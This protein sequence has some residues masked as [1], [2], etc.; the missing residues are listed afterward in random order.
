M[1]H[2]LSERAL[3]GL[4]QALAANAEG[5]DR[6][7]QFPQR[8]FDLL[9]RHGLLALTVPRALG[10]GGADLASAR[11]VIAAVGKGCPSTALILAMQYL[12]HSRLQE[13]ARWPEHLRHRVARDAVAHGALINALRVE[14]ELG[15][16]A[17]GGLPATLARRNAD[18]WRLSGRKLYSTG[19]H[20]LSW[21]LVWARSDD[22]DPLVGGFLVHKD[23]PGIT[24]VDD[25][26]H[27]GMRATCS[28][29]VRFDDVRIPLDHA[30]SVSPASA[31][32]AELDGQGL[33][34]MAVLLPA[35]Y[36]G[37]AQAARDWLVRFLKTRTPSNLGAP[38]ASLPRFQDVQGRIDTL[39]FAN[40]GLLDAAVGGQVEPCH[41]GQLKHVV[42]ANAIRAVE[43]AIEAA[44][45]P[46]LSRRNPLERHYRDV[47]C[48]RIHTPQDDTVLTQAG[49][50]AFAEVAP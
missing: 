31:P 10:G 41:A 47:L 30:V 26:D 19:S 7:A 36:D 33:L 37:V 38:L 6:S 11:R 35:L 13:D 43:L 2:P 45:N 23:T 15:T 44:G 1:S 29:E 39:L 8:N 24:I 34:W 27:L 50:T 14:P 5:Y 48:S 28:H 40:R 16:P 20:G 9:H 42:S 4:T 3:A 46:G 17:R 25:W 49:R 22:T 32:R 21:Y 18:G 12:Q